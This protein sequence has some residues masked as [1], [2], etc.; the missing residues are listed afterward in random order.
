MIL[1][2]R[3]FQEGQCVFGKNALFVSDFSSTVVEQLTASEQG[4]S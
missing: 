4:E 2:L 1:S 3:P